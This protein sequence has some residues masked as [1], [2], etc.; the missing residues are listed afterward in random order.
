MV[1]EF[2]QSLSIYPRFLRRYSFLIASGEG[3]IAFPIFFKKS[4]INIWN[5][6]KFAYLPAH[7]RFLYILFIYNI[8]NFYN[9]KYTI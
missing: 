4:S 3:V 6:K 1:I 9:R 8:Y 5:T 2:S 7:A